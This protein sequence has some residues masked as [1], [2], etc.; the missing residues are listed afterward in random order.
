MYSQKQG[1]TSWIALKCR[2]FS[3]WWDKWFLNNYL[4][5]C[6]QAFLIADGS[7]LKFRKTSTWPLCHPDL[8][9]A[10]ALGTCPRPALGS[11]EWR[12]Q[13]PGPTATLLG[14]VCVNNPR[15]TQSRKIASAQ[16]S[17]HSKNVP[18]P[19]SSNPLNFQNINNTDINHSRILK[20]AQRERTFHYHG[21]TYLSLEGAV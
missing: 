18:L 11:S 19:Q 14:S 12:L 21:W 10:N 7:V 2:L 15:T 17:F 6:A 4:P 9:G 13:L 1:K 8:Q 3:V 16:C 20:S 5:W